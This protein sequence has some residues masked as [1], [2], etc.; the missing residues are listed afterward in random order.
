M[1][2]TSLARRGVDHRII[3]IAGRWTSDAYA[4]YIRMTSDAKAKHQ[5]TFLNADVTHP[6]LIFAHENIP[7]NLLVRA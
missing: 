6:D 5:N 4:L 7:Q 3:Q 1:E 2:A